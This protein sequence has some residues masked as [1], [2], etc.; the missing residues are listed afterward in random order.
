MPIVVT[1]GYVF[2]DQLEDVL[3]Y[4]GGFEKM[5]WVV[6][7]LCAGDLSDPA[8]RCCMFTRERGQTLT[9]DGADRSRRA[10]A[11]D[12]AARMPG[13]SRASNSQW[14]IRFPALNLKAK[15]IA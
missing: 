6:I 15:L 14:H 11:L 5:I 3:H 13:P 1:L 12:D 10:A 8:A 7:A 4:I 2:G 9:S